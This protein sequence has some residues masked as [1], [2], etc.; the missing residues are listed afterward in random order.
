MMAKLSGLDITSYGSK[1]ENQTLDCAVTSFATKEYKT[2]FLIGRT[3]K[4]SACSE[5][6]LMLT[7]FINLFHLKAYHRPDHLI[8]I[9]E[10]H[11]KEL[12]IIPKPSFTGT[13]TQDSFSW[14]WPPP[15]TSSP[16]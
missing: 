7:S 6:Q 1:F 4:Q 12:S 13:R 11:G 3:K 2:P 9:V 15:V 8:Q 10:H 14:L 16:K 5:I